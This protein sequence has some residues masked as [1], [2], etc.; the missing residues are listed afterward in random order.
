MTSKE[1]KG[2][3]EIHRIRE[4]NYLDTKDM[5]EEEQ[6]KIFRTKVAAAKEKYGLK[7]RHLEK[8]RV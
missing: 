2:L 5:P 8:V 1:S 7:L 6:L 3:E 4:R